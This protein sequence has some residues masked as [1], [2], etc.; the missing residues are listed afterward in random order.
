MHKYVYNNVSIL[1]MMY[2]VMHKYVYNN[3][4]ISMMI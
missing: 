2:N 4:S 1:M 3:V